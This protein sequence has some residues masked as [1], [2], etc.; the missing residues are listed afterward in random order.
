NKASLT[1]GN[2][3]SYDRVSATIPAGVKVKGSVKITNVSDL[4]AA[5]SN[6]T[7]WSYS[8]QSY[9][10]FKNVAIEGRSHK[11][12]EEPRTTGIVTSCSDNL[13]FT[14]LDCKR[15]SSNTVTISYRVMNL[16]NKAVSLSLD[17]L[18][19]GRSY[20]YDNQGNQYNFG[21]NKASLTLGNDASYDRVSATIPG[22]VFTKGSVIIKDVDASATEMAN[23]TIWSYS[24]QAY[25]TFQNVKIR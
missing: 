14:L 18:T 22:N 5:F 8:E 13:E 19:S 21:Y 2:D 11:N 20:I 23:V 7:I 25:L 9:L 12:E 1:L 15:S 17:G 24:H 3:A 6:I 16:T 10:I 4:A